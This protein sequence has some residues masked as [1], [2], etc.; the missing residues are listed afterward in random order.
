LSAPIS[1]NQA[2]TE[3][4]V[5]RTD[6]REPETIGAIAIFA[7]ILVQA[8]AIIA[9]Y[10]YGSLLIPMNLHQFGIDSSSANSFT[11]KPCYVKRPDARSD[12]NIITDAERWTKS[13][14]HRW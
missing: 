10:Y 6:R 13:I 8:I 1:T 2:F 3:F 9:A 7:Q 4:G 14:Y 12:K 5:N 11:G